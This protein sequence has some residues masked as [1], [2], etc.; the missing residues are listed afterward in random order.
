[1]FCSVE[2]FDFTLYIVSSCSEIMTN[3]NGTTTTVVAMRV[4]DS[5][6]SISPNNPGGM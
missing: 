4:E 3:E 2:L 6:F 5:T 1:M